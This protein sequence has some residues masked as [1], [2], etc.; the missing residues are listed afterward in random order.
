MKVATPIIMAIIAV[1]MMNREA[2]LDGQQRQ[3]KGLKQ[4]TEVVFC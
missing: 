2:K 4:R 1:M 3:E